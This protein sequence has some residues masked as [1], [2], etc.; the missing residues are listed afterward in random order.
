MAFIYALRV[1]SSTAWKIILGVVTVGIWFT[2]VYTSHHYII[3]VLGGIAC[4]LA[5]FIIFEYGL[6]KIKS[7]ARFMGAYTQYIAR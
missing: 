6:M 3:D 4:A 2:A 1:G 7:V 5:G